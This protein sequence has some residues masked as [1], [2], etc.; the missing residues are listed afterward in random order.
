M[1]TT[2]ADPITSRLSAIRALLTGAEWARIA[3][4]PGVIV[5]LHLVGR[6]TL[7]AVVAPQH[8]SLGGKPSAW[9][10]G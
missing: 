1:T 7:V 4:I 8:F 6:V 3:A 9:A 5:A 2:E 10:P